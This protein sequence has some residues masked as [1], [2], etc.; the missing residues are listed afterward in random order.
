M[1]M[2]Q[3]NIKWINIEN[4]SVRQTLKETIILVYNRQIQIASINHW[5]DYIAAFFSET[6]TNNTKYSVHCYKIT[7]RCL[8]QT[9]G[10]NLHTR[11]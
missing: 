4:N 5:R 9:A 10:D 1:I 7:L 6:E 2:P 3:T 11:Y 8:R